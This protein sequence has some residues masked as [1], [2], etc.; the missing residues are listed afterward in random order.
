MFKSPKQEIVGAQPHGARRFVKP[1]GLDRLDS[2]TPICAF[3]RA[4]GRK[5]QRNANNPP[6]P[7]Q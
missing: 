7:R 1:M 5:C 3:L 2:A 6:G 4:E